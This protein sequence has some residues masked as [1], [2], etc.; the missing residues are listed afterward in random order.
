MRIDTEISFSQ[1]KELIE[2]YNQELQ[3]KLKEIDGS[4]NQN[5]NHYSDLFLSNEIVQKE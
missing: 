4:H 2:K 5:H 3:T 1:H